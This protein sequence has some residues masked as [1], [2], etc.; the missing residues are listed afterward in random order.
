MKRGLDINSDK[1]KT[2]RI[3]TTNLQAL[4]TG[5]VNIEDV[6]KFTYL[7]TVVIRGGAEEDVES[8]IRKARNAYLSLRKIWKARYISKELNY[9]AVNDFQ[10]KNTLI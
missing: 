7:S 4:K 9:K 8:R 5:D 6:E 10:E 3:N 1:T 2:M